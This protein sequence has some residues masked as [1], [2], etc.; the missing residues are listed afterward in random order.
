ML[1]FYN[2]RA[3]LGMIS[4]TLPSDA[5]FKPCRP[6]W[7]LDIWCYGRQKRHN[8]GKNGKVRG[9]IWSDSGTIWH[10]QET[11]AWRGWAGMA[12]IRLD[13]RLFKVLAARGGGAV[14]ELKYHRQSGLSRGW[15]GFCIPHA[16]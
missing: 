10:A 4:T 16:I 1:P 3:R 12:R 9:T 5:E 11:V 6:T 15:P 7:Q 8:R 14:I 2:G 13:M